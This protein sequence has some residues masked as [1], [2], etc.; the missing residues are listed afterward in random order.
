MPSLYAEGY[1]ADLDGLIDM[2]IFE[3]DGEITTVSSD[4]YIDGKLFAVPVCTIGGRANF[5]NID[6]FNEHGW[7]MKEK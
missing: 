7:E 4:V 6:M 3:P 1:I 5:Y 2:S